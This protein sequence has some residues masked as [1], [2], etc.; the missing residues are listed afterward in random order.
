MKAAPRELDIFE[1]H[2]SLCRTLANPTRLKVLA[3]LGRRETSVGEMA[4]VIGVSVP[5]ISQHLAVLRAHDLVETRKRGQTVWY[6]LADRRII[7]A[8]G[9]IRSV[10]LD[11]MKARGVVAR[12]A[13][14]RYVIT[15]R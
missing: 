9:T 11:H 5:N 7:K 12:Q 4:D 1:L 13:D 6:R 15:M 3:L 8:C 10:L 14:P 2:A